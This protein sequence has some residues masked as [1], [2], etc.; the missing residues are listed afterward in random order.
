MIEIT[1]ESGRLVQGHPMVLNPR[2]NDDGTPKIDKSG[3]PSMQVYIGFAIPKKGET[4]WRQTAWG[5]QI[6]QEATQS[7]PRGEHQMPTFAWKITD[8]DSQIPNRANKRPCDREGFPGHWI[9]GC[10]NGYTPQVFADGNYATNVMQKDRIKTGDYCRIII[11]V[12]G[13]ESTTSPGLYINL[14]AFELIQPGPA[15]VTQTVDAQSSFSAAPAQAPANAIADP[16]AG[17][18]TPP[19]AMQQPAPPTPQMAPTPPVAPPTPP[20]QDHSLADPSYTAPDGKVYTRSQLLGFG[21]TA[22]HIATLP[23]A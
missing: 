2:T 20:A 18:V 5:Q 12:K 6:V 8:G 11:T 9:L 3:Q 17:M 22:E 10:T 15:I 23:S 16:N 14:E 1:T 21:W 7:W 19:L 13:N 4:D